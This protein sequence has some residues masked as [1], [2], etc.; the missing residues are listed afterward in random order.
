MVEIFLLV[1][2]LMG[3]AGWIALGIED[4]KHWNRVEANP[5]RI[6]VRVNAEFWED[7]LPHSRPLPWLQET[8]A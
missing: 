7:S 4:T 1:M 6:L 2:L 3:A 5:P 8:A